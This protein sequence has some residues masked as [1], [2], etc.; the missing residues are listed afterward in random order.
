MN[1]IV[2]NDR[3]VLE[4]EIGHGGYSKV[5]LAFDNISLRHVAV[6]VLKCNVN[7]NPNEFLMFNQ[8]AMTLAAINN[9]NVVK[10]YESGVY[11]DNPYLVMDYVRGRS[12]REILTD[13]KYLLVD[14]VY[15]YSLQIL[16][17]LEAM[18]SLNIIHRDLKPQNIIRK[19]D[20]TILLIDFGTAFISEVEYN[21]YQEKSGSV[22]GTIQY[23][24]PELFLQQPGSIE[25]DIYAFGITMFELFTG[26]FPFYDKNKKDLYLL[27]RD[28]Q[29]PSA[30]RFNPNVPVSFENIIYK[31]CEKDPKKRYKNVFEIR[32]DL[33]NAYEE[34]KNPKEEKKSFLSGLFKKGKK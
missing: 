22:I 13:K 4:S 33:M 30:R 11:E 9:K 3:Y 8:E 31:C 5:F 26:R 2:I 23:M 15:E 19:T 17:G 16:N 32:L 14:E 7:K 20:G 1:Q 25:T 21:L 28:S 29:F 27:I 12:L 6:K 18:H 24:A 10:V 34:Y